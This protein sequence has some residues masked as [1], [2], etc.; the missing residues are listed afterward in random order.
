MQKF[1]KHL[2]D[3][4]ILLLNF[5]CNCLF[6]LEVENTN[7]RIMSLK[8]LLILIFTRVTSLLHVFQCVNV[9]FAQSRR[10]QLANQRKRLFN[11]R[12][13]WHYVIKKRVND[14]FVTI[15]VS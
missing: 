15:M 13:N 14:P 10:V 8:F 4:N 9:T 3:F 12:E 2:T 6:W 1:V 11:N 7:F 5:V